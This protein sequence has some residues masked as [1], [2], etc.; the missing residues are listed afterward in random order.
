MRDKGLKKIL[1]ICIVGYHNFGIPKNLLNTWNENCLGLLDLCFRVIDGLTTTNAPKKFLTHAFVS[2]AQ[3]T[4]YIQCMVGGVAKYNGQLTTK[5]LTLFRHVYSN[6]INYIQI[7]QYL[8]HLISSI[9]CHLR[10]VA[11]KV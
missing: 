7:Y 11:D 9:K 6:F 3:I 8:N 4:V 2:D 5:G 1:N 10:Q